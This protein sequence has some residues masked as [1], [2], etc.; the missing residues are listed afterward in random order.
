MNWNI[1]LKSPA[2]QNYRHMINKKKKKKIN[3]M[4]GKTTNK[5][6]MKK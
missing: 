6:Y 2:K 4:G 1:V 5:G 3:S